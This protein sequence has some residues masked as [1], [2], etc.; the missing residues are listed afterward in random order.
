MA[1]SIWGGARGIWDRLRRASLRHSAGVA[2]ER[3]FVRVL[4]AS[5]FLDARSSASAR[6]L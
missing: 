3:L 1:V 5:A 4:K 2:S 6:V